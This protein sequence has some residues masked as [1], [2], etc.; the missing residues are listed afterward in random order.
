M[1]FI[2]N[3]LDKRL[4]DQFEKREAETNNVSESSSQGQKRGPKP[5]VR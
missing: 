3:I 1:I 5:K 2:E 4:I